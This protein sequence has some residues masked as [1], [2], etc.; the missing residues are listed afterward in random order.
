MARATPLVSKGSQSDTGPSARAPQLVSKGI[1]APQG[2][3][4]EHLSS[5]QRDSKSQSARKPRPQA[6]AMLLVSER[7]REAQGRGP[8]QFCWFQGSQQCS[9]PSAERTDVY[10]QYQRNPHLDIPETASQTWGQNPFP[11]ISSQTEEDSLR[12]KL[13]TKMLKRQP[14]RIDGC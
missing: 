5:S 2:P 11:N 14:V 3:G 4:P 13:E 7:L 10:T 1:K 6:K 12:K 8:R 9:C